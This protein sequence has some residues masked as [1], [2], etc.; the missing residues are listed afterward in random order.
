MVVVTPS[1]HRPV[2]CF[3]PEREA[4]VS[5]I[6]RLAAPAQRTHQSKSIM[7]VWVEGRPESEQEAILTAAINPAWGHVAL[8]RELQSEG[9]PEISDNSFRQW[10]LKRGL[11]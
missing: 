6:E 11:K 2:A 3:V 4:P 8:L 5:L 1:G 10:R 9:A 7:D